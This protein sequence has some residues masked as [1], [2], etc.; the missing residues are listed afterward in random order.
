MVRLIR[1]Q[2]MKLHIQFLLFWGKNS[3]QAKKYRVYN[4]TT[5]KN[6]EHKKRNI[7]LQTH[8][9]KLPLHIHSFFFVGCGV[10]K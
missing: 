1:T 6:S 8:S 4:F 9:L 3:K 10:F 2:D 5:F 7:S